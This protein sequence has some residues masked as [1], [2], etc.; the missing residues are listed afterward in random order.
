MTVHLR[1][2]NGKIWAFSGSLHDVQDVMDAAKYRGETIVRLV[3]D[4]GRD[5]E[6]PPGGAVTE[7]MPN[8]RIGHGSALPAGV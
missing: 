7:R 3:D 6:L 8:T 2:P 4:G 1:A 5:I